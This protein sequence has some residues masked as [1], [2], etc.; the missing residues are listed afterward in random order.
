MLLMVS[1]QKPFSVFNFCLKLCAIICDFYLSAVNNLPLCR[2]AEW[3]HPSSPTLHFLGDSRLPVGGR[4]G[5]SGMKSA[6]LSDVL[7]RTKTECYYSVVQWHCHCYHRFYYYYY[8]LL[9]PRLITLSLRPPTHTAAESG[10]G[11]VLNFFH[12]SDWR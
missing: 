12:Q 9:L 1:I 7:R 11:T 3:Q 4:S 5:C 6:C 2:C 8:S 10:I